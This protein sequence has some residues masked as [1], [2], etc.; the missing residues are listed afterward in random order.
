MQNDDAIDGIL[1]TN[2]EDMPDEDT[3]KKRISKCK[4]YESQWKD[5]CEHF[6]AN[7][8]TLENRNV[9]NA[10]ISQD[11]MYYRQ[12]LAELVR[13]LTSKLNILNK[14]LSWTSLK[15]DYSI[16]F[17]IRK[18]SFTD[19]PHNFKVLLKTNYIFYSCRMI[20]MKLPPVPTPRICKA[21]IM[22]SYEVQC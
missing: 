13:F 12:R 15:I 3:L 14:T 18:L 9:D 17:L 16:F 4:A 1:E 5:M 21:E 19:F 6:A 2:G 20:L 22:Y 7:Y 11:D 8:L 10:K